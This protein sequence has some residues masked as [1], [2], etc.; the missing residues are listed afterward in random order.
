MNAVLKFEVSLPTFVPSP[1]TGITS[2]M[3][4]I[5]KPAKNRKQ[6]FDFAL[7]GPLV[8]I[9]ASV[10]LL[11]VGLQLT[12][13]SDPQAVA[14]FPKVPVELLRQSGLSANIIALVLGSGAIYLPDPSVVADLSSVVLSLHPFAVAGFFSAVVNALALLPIGCES[15]SLIP[16]FQSGSNI[17]CTCRHR[18]WKNASS[19]RW[20]DRGWHHR[21][22]LLCISALQWYFFGQ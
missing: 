16:R 19:C 15:G 20:P 10:A 13:S 2:S 18:R 3:T 14:L 1:V 8:G 12:A 5:R 7:A 21:Y 17:F 4:D 11:F 9:I 6:L 22:S